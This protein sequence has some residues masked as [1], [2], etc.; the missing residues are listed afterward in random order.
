VNDSVTRRAINGANSS[1][2]DLITDVGIQFITDDL[3][4]KLRKNLLTSSADGGC[5]S[6]SNLPVYFIS[7]CKGFMSHSLFASLDFIVAL[8]LLS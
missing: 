8:I 7:D 3:A 1:T 6:V 2:D 4:G 5:K